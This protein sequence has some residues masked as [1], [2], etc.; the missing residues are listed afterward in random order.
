MERYQPQII[1]TREIISESPITGQEFSSNENSNP[2]YVDDQKIILK[3][4][5]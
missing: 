2:N 3:Q 4:K 5:K 1:K